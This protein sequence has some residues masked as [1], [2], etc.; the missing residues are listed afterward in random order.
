VQ[1]GGQWFASPD[2]ERLTLSC[3][4]CRGLWYDVYV[5]VN[6]ANDRPGLVPLDDTWLRSML[7]DN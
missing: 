6:K 3:S 4:D 1:V 2:T 7:S 5:S